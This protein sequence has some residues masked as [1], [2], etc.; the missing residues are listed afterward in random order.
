MG[1][2]RQ[3]R[4]TLEQL[5]DDTIKQAKMFRISAQSF[6]PLVSEEVDFALGIAVGEIHGGFYNYF[7]VVSRRAMNDE[8]LVEMYHVIRVRASEIRNAILAVE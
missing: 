1:L 8:E 5:I 6:K 4:E 2:T 7:T 3:L